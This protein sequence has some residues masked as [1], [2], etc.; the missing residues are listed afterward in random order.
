MADVPEIAELDI[1][2]LIVNFEGAI[3]LDA[4][5]HL[6]ATRSAVA[7]NFAIQP[8][9]ADLEESLL[10]QDRAVCLRPIRPEYEALHK[11]FLQALD[12]EDVHMRVF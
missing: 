8:Y 5:I 3:A 6:A 11:E 1:D 2:P 10:W 9:P 7:K 12:L 4:P